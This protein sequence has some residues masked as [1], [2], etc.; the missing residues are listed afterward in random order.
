MPRFAQNA[1]PKDR[2][3]ERPVELAR[4][5][6]RAEAKVSPIEGLAAAG[7]SSI[8]RRGT[9]VLGGHAGSGLPEGRH[10][11]GRL[12]LGHIDEPLRFAGIAK[13]DRLAIREA[14]RLV[15]PREDG[16]LARIGLE[17]LAGR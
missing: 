13:V 5:S 15:L 17:D 8:I 10:G 7:A 16:G 9:R 14:Q 3:A 11:Y 2:R 1:R 4:L 6:R 12:G